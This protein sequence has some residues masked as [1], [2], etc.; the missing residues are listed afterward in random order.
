MPPLTGLNNY[1]GCVFY[2]DTAPPA[3]RLAL[4]N[5]VAMVAQKISIRLG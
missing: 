4:K 2:K 1:W 5:D 3:L